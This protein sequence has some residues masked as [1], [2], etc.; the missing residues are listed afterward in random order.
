MSMAVAMLAACKLEQW[1]NYPLRHLM[2]ADP[3]AHLRCKERGLLDHEL[4]HAIDLD[5]QHCCECL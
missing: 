2:P 4:Q 5:V 3:C 1:S